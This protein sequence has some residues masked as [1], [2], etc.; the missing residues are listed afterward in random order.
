MLVCRLIRRQRP[1]LSRALKGTAGRPRGGPVDRALAAQ[2]ERARWTH[3]R[4]LADGWGGVV[5]PDPLER[6]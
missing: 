2:L 5:L 1:R 3:R 6:K 4:D